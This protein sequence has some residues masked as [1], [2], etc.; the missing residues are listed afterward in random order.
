MD[1][2]G[3]AHQSACRY[4][5]FVAQTFK[6]DFVSDYMPADIRAKALSCV[7]SKIQGWVAFFNPTKMGLSGNTIVG[8]RYANSTCK[9]YPTDKGGKGGLFLRAGE[10]RVA[11]GQWFGEK[12]N[13]YNSSL[14]ISH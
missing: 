2:A 9:L 13:H 1:F 12:V 7:R 6:S 14:T 8:L 5:V 10:G 4:R 11:R 3:S